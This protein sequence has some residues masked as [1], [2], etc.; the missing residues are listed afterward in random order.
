MKRIMFQST[1]LLVTL[2][3][4]AAA[5][6]NYFQ[7][8]NLN[9]GSV[10]LTTT[11]RRLNTT[12]TSHTFTIAAPDSVTV[13]VHVNSRFSVGSFSSNA[14]GVM[15]QVRIDD[16]IFPTVDNHGSLLTANSSAFLSIY[17]VFLRIPP[18]THRVSI[19]GRTALGAA[20]SARVD[21]AGWGGRIIVKAT[22]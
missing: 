6:S 12:A 14:N 1:L 3:G 20:S 8:G 4:S 7:F 5:Q 19:W 11:W 13:E 16:R 21:P 2:T 22:R 10:N 9:Q 18:G 15:F 17:A